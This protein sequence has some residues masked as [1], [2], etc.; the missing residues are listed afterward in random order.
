MLFSQRRKRVI[1]QSGLI[2]LFNPQGEICELK[3]VTFERKKNVGMVTDIPKVISIKPIDQIQ[4]LGEIPLILASMKANQAFSRGTFREID[5]DQYPGNV[6]AINFL[7]KKDFSVD[8]LDCL[9]SVEFETLVAKIFEASNC[10]VPAYKGGFIKDVDLFVYGGRKADL[11]ELDAVK[12]DIDNGLSY[13]AT[14]QLKLRTV[15]NGVPLD[16]F[17]ASGHNLI[18]LDSKP[19]EALQEWH[20]KQYFTREWVRESI[21]R[22]PAAKKWLQQS[23][24]WLPKK[25]K[26]L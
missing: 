21:R 22:F 11:L 19:I 26:E 4:E 24:W 18:T 6:A 9:S 8:P 5:K 23:L 13:H 1:P 10:F 15:K 20:G 25:M 16:W 3:P 14:V 17:S 7:L 2:W 12:S